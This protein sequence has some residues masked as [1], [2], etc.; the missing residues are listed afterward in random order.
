MENTGFCF[1]FYFFLFTSDKGIFCSP[2]ALIKE[3]FNNVII[4][5]SFW[6]IVSNHQAILAV[7]L[8]YSALDCNIDV[9][10][11]PRNA[12][13]K[14]FELTV[15]LEVNHPKRGFFFSTS[16][17]CHYDFNNDPFT[18]TNCFTF[19]IGWSNWCFHWAQHVS[20]FT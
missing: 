17:H 15:Y 7:D 16:L 6:N 11:N 4:N 14:L 12:K 5:N 20:C 13:S 1:S 18:P 19:I 9:S 3:P 10:R 8:I 2:K